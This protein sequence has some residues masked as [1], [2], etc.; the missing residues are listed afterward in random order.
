MESIVIRLAGEPQAKLRPRFVRSTGTAFTPSSTRKYES[1]LRYAAQVEMIGRPVMEGPIEVTVVAAFPVPLHFSRKKRAAALLG[2]IRPAKK[3][4]CDN[5]LK[6]LDAFN[7]VVWQDDKQIVKAAI[8]KVYSERPELCV[9][10]T[11]FKTTYV[12]PLMAPWLPP[13]HTHNDVQTGETNGE[14]GSTDVA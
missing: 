5:L 14:D 12:E 9:V 3:P 11:P 13:A 2:E 7:Q 10:I 8:E 1:A 4:D 6:Q